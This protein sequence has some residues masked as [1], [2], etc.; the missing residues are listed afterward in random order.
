[1]FSFTEILNK[2]ADGEDLS[3]DEAT[4]AIKSIITGE[5]SEARISA[6][7]FGMRMKG[8]SVEELTAIVKVMR[9]AV[10][11]VDVPLDNAIDLC[12]T[13]GDQSGTFNISTGAMFVAAGAGVPVLKHGNRSVSSKSGSADV[14]EALGAVA[15]LKKEEVEKMFNETGMAF[16]F[17]PFFHPAMKEVMPARRSLKLRTFFNILGPLLN[18]AKVKRQVIGAYSQDVANKIVQILSNLDTEFAYGVNSHD[19]M[20]EFSIN[21][22]T[23]VYHLQNNMHSDSI[24][25]DPRDLGFTL[26]TMEE[27]QGGDKEKNAEIIRSI[28]EDKATDAQRDVILL[29]ALFAIHASGIVDDL[30][31]AHDAALDSLKSGRALKK[32]NEFVTGTN[33]IHNSN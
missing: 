4:F 12:G 33:D 8:E 30:E 25:F 13:G 28:L 19:G 7:L 5:V 15:T 29:N 3:S 14:L 17:A 24:R 31:E 21:T 22:Y 11:Q 1:M 9:D 32:L 27:I 2:L 23:E 26:A 20:D 18:P 16:M 6:F 10:V